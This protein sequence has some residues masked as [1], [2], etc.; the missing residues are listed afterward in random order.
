VRVIAIAAVLAGLAGLGAARAPAGSPKPTPP[1]VVFQRPGYET[2]SIVDLSVR[3]NGV[4][5]RGRQQHVL[6]VDCNGVGKAGP[7]RKTVGGFLEFT[8]SRFVCKVTTSTVRN[9]T[10]TVRW[11]ADNTYRYDFPGL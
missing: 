2:P 6:S 8:Y 10:M 11:W 4:H 1:S 7:L 5:L 3:T 9:V